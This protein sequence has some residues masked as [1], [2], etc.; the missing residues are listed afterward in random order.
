MVTGTL[1]LKSVPVTIYCSAYF[2]VATNTPS[3]SSPGGSAS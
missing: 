3:Q 1:F 2:D